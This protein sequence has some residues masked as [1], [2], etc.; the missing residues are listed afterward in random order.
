MD[1]GPWDLAS[2]VMKAI[3]YGATFAVTGGVLFLAYSAR[4][5]S[6][7]QRAYI[8]G[9]LGLCLAVALAASLAR[10]SVLAG[11]MAES[12]A[13]MFDTAMLSMVL[14]AGEV[15]ATGLRILGLV[16]ASVALFRG[17]RLTVVA[18]IGAVLSS[19]SFAWIGHAWASSPGAL[20]VSVQAVH[21]VSV[22]FWIGALPPLRRIARAGSLPELSS[23]ARRFGDL[24]IGAVG[25]LIIAG[26]TL[27]SCLLR[28]P[29]ELWT[30]PYG[31][32]IT[33]KLAAVVC[34]LSLA[35]LNR[36]RLTPRLEAGDGQAARA[37]AKSIDVEI[38]VGAVILLAT[39]ALTTVTGPLG[40]D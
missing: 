30:T 40:L 27:L 16:L 2:V 32:L 21:L 19:A 36:L 9:W 34:L 20:L 11:S 31:R 35:A 14:Q 39:A 1:V 23:I 29:A 38:A 5:I 7:R 33:L 10:I 8:R 28:S 12:P 3:A 15:R 37:L 26:A 18:V 17:C 25:L 6:L 22:G 4:L 13:G 24:A